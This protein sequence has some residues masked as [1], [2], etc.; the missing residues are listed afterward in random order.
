MIGR[1]IELIRWALN[2]ADREGAWDAFN[3]IVGSLAEAERLLQEAQDRDLEDG[4]EWRERLDAF[5][6]K[7]GDNK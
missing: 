6:A 4:S 5:L 3:R 1:D 2:A 7:P